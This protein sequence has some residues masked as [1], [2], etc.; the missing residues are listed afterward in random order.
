MIQKGGLSRGSID[1]DRKTRGTEEGS[2]KLF[3]VETGETSDGLVST[4]QHRGAEVRGRRTEGVDE[5][6]LILLEGTVFI[7]A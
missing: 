2:E 7:P 4:K 5:F 6:T 1:E 3:K